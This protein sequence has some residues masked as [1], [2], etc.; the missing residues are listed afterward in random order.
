MRMIRR[1][2]LPVIFNKSFVIAVF[3]LGVTLVFS[4]KYGLLPW[5]R[6]YMARKPIRYDDQCNSSIYDTKNGVYLDYSPIQKY[7]DVL[8]PTSISEPGPGKLTPVFVTGTSSNHFR[9]SMQMLDNFRHTVRKVI[10]GAKLIFYN[11]GLTAKEVQLL[12][13]MCDLEMR[14]FPFEK[15][16][17]HVKLLYGYAF[18]P[19]AI[20]TVLNEH[21]LVLWLDS[22]VRFTQNNLVE[23]FDDANRLDLICTGGDGTVAGRT[24]ASTFWYFNIEPCAFRSLPEIQGGFVIFKRTE[25]IENKIVK[26]WVACGL[27]MGCMMPDTT[28]R[29]YLSC[30]RNV[31]VYADC[32]RFDQ[33]VLAILLY[34][35]YG[36]RLEQ[37][38]RSFY[39]PYYIRCTI[40]CTW[41]GDV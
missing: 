5:K 12:K 10:P 26:P 24:L 4:L 38:K 33:S 29:K 41:D 1:Q 28:P 21:P 40:G 9:E 18:K 27:T 36:T 32:H 14:D 31:Y 22:S 39:G 16:P 23:L 25:F 19:I 8:F 2:Y 3:G 35:T 7:L 13:S 20:Q 11:L 15:Y 37:H 30:E 34:T 17:D 6:L